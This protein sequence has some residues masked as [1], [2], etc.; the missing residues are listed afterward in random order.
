MPARGN[1]VLAMTI[2]LAIVLSFSFV[3]FNDDAYR[4]VP[5]QYGHFRRFQRV[6]ICETTPWVRSFSGY[7]TI[8]PNEDSPVESN[9]FF[10]FFEARKSPRKAPL[11][12]WLQGGPG[13]GSIGQAVSGHS[14]P[15]RVAG[16]DGTATELN[17]WSWNNEANMLYVDQPVL[18]GY[19]YDAI[20]RGFRDVTSGH[21]TL[22]DDVFAQIPGDNATIRRGVFPSQ[23][24]NNAPNTTDAS[25]AQ[26]VRFLD[27]WTD[28]FARYRHDEINIWAQSYGGHYAPALAS[29]LMARRRERPE[30]MSVASV[31]IINGFVDMLLQA[32]SLTTFPVNNTF[33]IKAYSEEVAA[34]ARAILPTCIS[35]GGDCQALQRSKARSR[36][37]IESACAAAFAT[38]WGM[39][40]L[41]DSRA[42]RGVFDIAHQSLDPFP[43]EYVVGWL[44][45]GKVRRKLGAR[46]NYTETSGPTETAFAMTGDFMRSSTDEL[47]GLI[48]AGVKVA[49]VFGDRDFRC[50]WVGGEAVSLALN[51]SKKEQFAAA[52]YTDL[53]TNSTYIG[54]KVRQQGLFSFT[55]VFQAGHEVPMYQP[56]TAYQIFMRTITGRDVATGT[57]D[58]VKDAGFVTQGPLSV[59]DV[60][61]PPPQQPP[62]ECYID[63]SPLGTRCTKEQVAALTNGTAVVANRVVVSPAA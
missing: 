29:A 53:K 17:P 28:D 16:P 7:I 24:G 47:V 63:F 18:T 41:Y 51:H 54:G 60:Q 23:D 4:S 20:S 35:Q 33:G 8:P 2:G 57:V 6:R 52:G 10:M 46:V 22:G 27:I 32:P 56:E 34:Q 3:L 38:C 50:N 43:P 31:G 15:C 40:A 39:A 59:F 42:D 61:Q 30:L 26:L 11:T 13:S 62:N 5:A 58:V 36:G 44:N 45:N 37:E 49:L 1:K 9:M 12:L 19:S 48:D 14:G 55:R 21:V 25:V